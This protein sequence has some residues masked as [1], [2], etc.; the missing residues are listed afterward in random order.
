MVKSFYDPKVEK[1]GIEKGIEKGIKFV[2]ENMIKDGDSNDKIKRNTSLE[3]EQIDEIRKLIKSNG[4]HWKVNSNN[5][6]SY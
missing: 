5:N 6:E 3:E 1:K 2:A 4:E